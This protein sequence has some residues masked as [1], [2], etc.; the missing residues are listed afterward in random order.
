MFADNLCTLLISL[1]ELVASSSSDDACAF[2]RLIVQF[3]RDIHQHNP[4]AQNS[5]TVVAALHV[6][7]ATL[8]SVGRTYD[9]VSM[10]RVLH[11]LD[12]QAYRDHFVASL[13]ALAD[14]QYACGKIDDALV[15]RMDCVDIRYAVYDSCRTHES[16]MDVVQSMQRLEDVLGHCGHPEEIDIQP[17]MPI[18]DYRN[19]S[20]GSSTTFRKGLVKCLW[21]LAGFLC[22]VGHMNGACAAGRQAVTICRSL[23]KEPP[24]AF[25][26]HLADSLWRLAALFCAVGRSH[27]AIAPQREVVAMYHR[28]AEQRPPDFYSTLA[29]SLRRLARFLHAVGLRAD[30]I[31]AH[32]RA[33]SIERFSSPPED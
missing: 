29:G 26:K 12:P 3:I 18:M 2:A 16:R 27:D 5:P 4:D 21:Q 9:I 30:A 6:L 28:L 1:L 23:A 11:T 14:D 8:R 22:K 33:V 15:T 24:T 13:H 17:Q 7:A 31:A 25:H 10:F 20:Q 19:P 32:K